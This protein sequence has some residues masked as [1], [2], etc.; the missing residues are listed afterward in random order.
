[1]TS[2]ATPAAAASIKDRSSPSCSLHSF[3]N[4][5]TCHSLQAQCTFPARNNR[6]LSMESHRGPRSRIR[7]IASNNYRP[8]TNLNTIGEMI[9]RLAQNQ[10]R[11]RQDRLSTSPIHIKHVTVGLLIEGTAVNWKSYH[12]DRQWSAHGRTDGQ[13]ETSCT[14][15]LYSSL[16][17][18]LSST[19]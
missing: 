3:A 5:P 10:L 1:M 11:H 12:Q 19:C 2:I 8:I 6:S 7:I 17:I 18:L 4:R 15:G 16:L 13:T 14:V 9:E